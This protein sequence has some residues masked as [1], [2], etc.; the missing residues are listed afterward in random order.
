M[1]QWERCIDLSKEE[2]YIWLFSDDDMMSPNCVEKFY[3]Q[4]KANP[5]CDILHFNVNVIDKDS[6]VIKKT[7]Y[8]EFVSA[9]D[10]YIGKLKYTLDC[11]VVE[12]IFKREV[13]DKCK[14]FVKFD[15]AWGSDLATWVKF[16]ENSGV[17]TV[18]DATVNW[19]SSGI[20]ISTTVDIKTLQRKADALVEFLKWGEQMFPESEIHRMNSKAL[21]QRLANMNGPKFAAPYIDKYAR[22]KFESLAMR[23]FCASYYNL[24]TLLKK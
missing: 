6:N 20:N 9:K 23:T 24:K 3:Q 4:I 15:L 5:D 19:R 1:A 21:I 16:A 2:P 18:K 8:P 17:Q 11:Y 14:G 12:F 13:Y 22:N 10:L 7:V